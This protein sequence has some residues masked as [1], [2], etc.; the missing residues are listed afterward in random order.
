VVLG[1]PI[2]SSRIRPPAEEVRHERRR[3]EQPRIT[4][5]QA[6][7][8][9]PAYEVRDW[10]EHFGVSEEAL[11]AA[12]GKVGSSAARVAKELGKAA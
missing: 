7:Q 11:R 8:P 1:N 9:D 5:P 10:A 2:E 4:G 6:D 12:V 3:Q